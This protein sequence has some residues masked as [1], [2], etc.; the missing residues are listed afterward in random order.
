MR[1]YF[2]N[3]LNITAKQF[4]SAVHISKEYEKAINESTVVS[5]TN[6]AGEIIYVNNSLDNDPLSL[7]L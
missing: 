4:S 3:Q 6:I 2:Q 5:R 7:G 1:E